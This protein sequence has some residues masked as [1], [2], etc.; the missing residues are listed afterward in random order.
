MLSLIMATTARLGYS[1]RHS[2]PH[3]ADPLPLDEE[4]SEWS[5]APLAFMTA[6]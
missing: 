5:T 6:I 4:L 3:K 2:Y 1:A